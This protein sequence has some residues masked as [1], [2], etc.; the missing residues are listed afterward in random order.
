[1]KITLRCER[2][3]LQ[4]LRVWVLCCYALGLSQNLPALNATDPSPD[5]S[6]VIPCHNERDNLVPLTDSIRTTLEPVGIR[7]EV[8]LTDDGSTDGSWDVIGKLHAVDSR[9]RAL[10]FA[11]NCGQ[12]AALWAGLQAARGR[13]IVTLDA[14][15][16]NDPRDIPKLLDALKQFDCACGNRVAARSQG[17]S[18]V[19]RVSSRIANRVRNKWSDEN[20]A[21]AGCCFRAFKRECIANVRCFKGFHRFLPTLIKM[22]GFTVMEVPVSH[23]PRV[24]GASH[25]GIGNRLFASLADL[26][27]VRWMKK[28]MIRYMIKET[29]D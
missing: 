15:L 11:N 20:I 7:F 28:R 26:L 10:R 13:H 16:Q 12:S 2:K 29:M 22:E 27:A 6:V 1:M 4:A 3:E 23:N 17:D 14:D 24:S 25:Y 19:K 9:V 8:I 21:D 18:W 5:L